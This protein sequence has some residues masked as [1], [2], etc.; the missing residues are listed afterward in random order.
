MEMKGRTLTGNLA[1]GYVTKHPPLLHHPLE[2]WVTY[3]VNHLQIETRG[4]SHCG[5][6]VYIKK[7]LKTKRRIME[8]QIFHT[9]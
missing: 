7:Y 1:L 3:S 9:M 5:L 2:S 6:A 4:V 8:T